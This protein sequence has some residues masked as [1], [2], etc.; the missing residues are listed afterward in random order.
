MRKAWFGSWRETPVYDMTRLAPG[1]SLTGPAILEAETTTV[2]VN[3]GDKLVVNGL[4]WLDIAL[5]MS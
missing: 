3:A 1:A 5:R 2:V 4:G